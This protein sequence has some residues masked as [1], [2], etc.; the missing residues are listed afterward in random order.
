MVIVPTI[1][2]M[3][4]LVA[5]TSAPPFAVTRASSPPDAESAKPDFRDVF[6]SV[7]NSFAEKYTV[8]NL[9]PKDVAIKIRAGAMNSGNILTS[10]SA[11]TETKKS[12]AN[13]SRNG[14]DSTRAIAWDF[15]SA[16]STPAKNAPAATETPI[17]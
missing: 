5:P 16:T 3:N 2:R 17:R 11:P 9:A 14:I 8:A 6:L 10:M 12:A 4:A 13:M 15:D 7:P 1:G